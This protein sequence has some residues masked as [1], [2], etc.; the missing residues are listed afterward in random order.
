[1]NVKIISNVFATVIA[2]K[3]QFQDLVHCF[4]I[5]TEMKRLRRR[6][7][8]VLHS[9]ENRVDEELPSSFYQHRLGDQSFRQTGKLPDSLFTRIL[10]NSFINDH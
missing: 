9:T 8:A 5:H 2:S 6:L 7:K 10:L 4:R 1:M 3:Y